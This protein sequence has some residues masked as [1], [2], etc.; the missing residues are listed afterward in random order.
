MPGRG[1]GA[2]VYELHCAFVIRCSLSAFGIVRRSR[3]LRGWGWCGVLIKWN[4]IRYVLDYALKLEQS[5]VRGR[6]VA[7]E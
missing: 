4:G 2:L 3:D 1:G 5:R 7:V 6:F